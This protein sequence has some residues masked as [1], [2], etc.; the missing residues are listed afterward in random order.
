MPV[1]DILGSFSLSQVYAFSVL[2]VLAALTIGR[3]FG[4]RAARR[5]KSVESSLGSAVAAIMGLLA[6]LLAFTFNMAAERFAQRKALLLEE[7]NIIATTY[8]RA[9]LLELPA[10]ER[11]RALLAEYTALRKFNP[12]DLSDFESRLKRTEAIQEELWS[13]VVELSERGYDPLKLRDFFTP[14]NKVLDQHSARVLIGLYYQI[15][16]PVWV[17]LYAITALAMFAIGFQL[18]ISRRGSSQ[19]ALAL[20]LAFSLVILLIVDLDRSYE[21]FL[22]VDQTPME[23]LSRRFEAERGSAN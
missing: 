21:G 18:G 7:A 14:L 8:L 20:A 13:L 3:F 22:I 19:V 5:D 11:A 17:A 12:R 23:E 9:D 15:P 16:L 1:E 10:R 6:F 2:L 4:R